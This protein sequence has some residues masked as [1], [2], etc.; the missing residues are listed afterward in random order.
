MVILIIVGVVFAAVGVYGSRR[1]FLLRKK[2]QRVTGTV[3]RIDKQWDPG[4]GGP[5]NAGG[6]WSYTPVLSFQTLAGQQIETSSRIGNSSIAG[7]SVGVKEG[8]QVR[9]IYDPADPSDAEVDTVSAQSAAML[10]PLVAAVVGIGVFVAGI[11][12]MIGK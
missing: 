6:T 1:Q 3:T 10:L 7:F 9:V 8:Q 12:G 11:V 5:D 4:G 2:G